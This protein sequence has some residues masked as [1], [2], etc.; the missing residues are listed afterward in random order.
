[1]LC[2]LFMTQNV[3]AQP[4]NDECAT[5]TLIT[6]MATC[7]TTTVITTG[8][9]QSPDT[10]LLCPFAPTPDDDVWMAFVAATTDPRVDVTGSSGYD[11][12]IQ[13]WDG[14]GGNAL[15]CS[16]GT[17]A[18]LTE[19]IN[20]SGLTIGSTYYLRV[21]DYYTGP[22]VTD[23]FFVCVYDAPTGGP[24]NDDCGG[25]VSLTEGA[26]C[27][28]TTGDIALATSS[29]LGCVGTADDDVW[30]SFTAASVNPIIDVQ[31]SIGF[32]GVVELFDAC[33]GTSLF[34][35]DATL[36]GGLETI[37]STGLTIGNT[38]AIRVYDWYAAVPSTTTF[39]ICVR[40]APVPP[41]GNNDTCI[42][43]FALGCDTTIAGS[44]A[45]A[46]WDT[47]NTP[48]CP[49]GFITSPGVWYS[50]VSDGS[51]LTLSTCGQAAYDTRISLFSGSCGALVCEAS[52]DDGTGCSLTSLISE[53]P[54]VSGT[55]YYVLVHGYYGATGTFNL[56]LTCTPACTPAPVNED[57]A[58]AMTTTVA[59]AG[60]GTPVTI[61]NT[62]AAAGTTSP[63]CD[64]FGAIHDVWYSFNSGTN[65]SISITLALGT[66]TAAHYNVWDA[67]G[68][69]EIGACNDINAVGA[70]VIT[71]LTAS[72]TYY[73]Q[74]WNGTGEQ[75][76]FDLTLEGGP[77]PPANDLCSGA[78]WLTVGVDTCQN[79]A[80]GNNS[81]ASDSGVPTPSC[82]SY[83]GGDIWFTAIVPACGDL[84]VETSDAGGFTDSGLELFEGNCGTLTSLGCDDDGG[85]GLFSK[86][87]VTGLTP[88]DTVY[89][90]VWEYGNNVFG[91]VNV[92]AWAPARTCDVVTNLWTSHITPSSARLNWDPTCSAH[93]YRIRGRLISNANWVNIIIFPSDPNFKNVPVLAFG[94]TYVWQI[95]S[96]CD[97]AE[98]DSS[99]WSVLDTF[100]T[101]CLPPD[102]NW[103]D[104]IGPTGAQLNWTPRP[105]GA[106]YE[107]RGR[108]VG[109]TNWVQVVVGPFTTSFQAFGLNPATNYE[110][111]VR[112][113]C[114]TAGNRKSAWG[115]L[116]QFTT[117]GT[118]RLGSPDF[119]D[120]DKNVTGM[121][122]YPNPAS[123]QIS[124]TLNG[125]RV[126]DLS[127]EIYDM[128]G[129]LVVEPRSFEN[130]NTLNIDVESLPNG[131][132]HI[133]LNGEAVIAQQKVVITK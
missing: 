18:G 6:Q 60:S 113:W 14:C 117:L 126:E 42:N 116:I 77:A 105:F 74:L 3:S 7:V 119:F 92:C 45:T 28:N 2:G 129:Q 36:A 39:D 69:T 103:T 12:V 15:Y 23:T 120:A 22:P 81:G 26:T 65:T 13:L 118:P 21:F 38:Y 125:T 53:H 58:T 115:T 98:A 33:G 102:T 72:T 85:N 106:A 59:P 82:A 62:C 25:A 40:T 41:S 114:D 50:W 94:N 55:T 64:Q 78:I 71:G 130:G 35:Q 90:R 16:D 88:G 93:H 108:L 110:W 101:D 37:N 66:A 123:D 100:T 95:R 127:V 83:N 32:D 49:A 96:F 133:V 80:Q 56:T 109:N 30:Y 99:A 4:A 131:V 51:A 8:A 89:I 73:L 31:G 10:T 128:K 76:T 86:M 48:D 84:T 111:Q 68:G 104:P 75:G 112:T 54:T 44:T 132:Y 67:C 24:A 52:N 124:L 47:T 63:S 29:L 121:S 87:T 1:M 91:A 9:T 79:P 70:N 46:T 43:A 17:L 57:C 27:V 20:A 34:C 122:V 61:D 5:A 11:P 107:F 19:T 97:A